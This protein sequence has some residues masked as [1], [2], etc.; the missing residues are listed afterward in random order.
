MHRISRGLR[1]RWTEIV[2]AAIGIAVIG[3]VFFVVLPRIANYGDVWRTVREVSWP[4]VLALIAAAVLNVAT[5]GPP[6]MAA[7]PGLRYR[8]ALA[9]SLAS[10]ASTYVAPGGPA[11][12]IALSFAMLKGW[13]FQSKAITTAVTLTTVWNQF[14][15]FGMPSLAF[16]LLSAEGGSQPLLRSAATAGMLVLA[17]SSAGLAVALSSARLARAIGNAASAIADA[18][19]R[20]VRR[21]PVTWSGE[22]L[23]AFREGTR[24]LLRHRWHL[25]TLWTLAG[26]LTVYAVLIV[27]LRA[28]G[29]DGDQVSLAESFA[30]WTIGRVIGAI[31]ITP[32]GFGLVE[33]GLTGAL[34]GFGASDADAVAA[35][36][37]YRFLTVGPPLLLGVIAGATWRQH[38]DADVSDGRAIEG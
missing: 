24:D 29:V 20:L 8:A 30:A 33:V 35:V 14:M 34:V 22:S 7:L 25:L 3:I 10:T 26:H 36:L 12:G 27:T 21:R 17:A 31:P 28:L 15:T 23:V 6:I 37:V 2:P 38:N 19:L 13:G 4:W 32:G 1:A 5:F 11:V 16:A 18:G 9:S